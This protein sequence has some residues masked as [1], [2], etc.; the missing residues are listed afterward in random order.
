MDRYEITLSYAE[1]L[2]TLSK[3][4]AFV[5]REFLTWLWYLSESN[6]DFFE[7]KNP[8]ETETYRISC[9]IDDRVTL[10]S[11][12]SKAHVHNL[13]GGDPSQSAEAAAALKTGKTVKD[14]K[15]GL[16]IE[17]FGEATFSLSSDDLSP[18]SISWIESDEISKQEIEEQ[19]LQLA[20]RLERASAI[21][22]IMD[23]LFR[24][25]LI[26]FLQKDQPEELRAVM[27]HWIEQRSASSETMLN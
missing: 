25:F 11:L 9:W 12:S 5:G 1:R 18:R 19:S 3:T 16:H 7:I 22:D 14:L 6:D 8:D 23:G 2:R 15:L 20:V 13:R 24:R 17:G 4:K 21:A 26:E 27:R 10:S